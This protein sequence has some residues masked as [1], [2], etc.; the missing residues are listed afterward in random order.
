MK[1]TMVKKVLADGSSCKKCDQVM[2]KLEE[3]GYISRIDEV[4]EARENDPKSQGAQLAYVL[5]VTKAPFFV[6][7]RGEPEP[8][9]YTIYFKLVKEVFESAR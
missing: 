3:S 5:G 8:E 7:D 2:Q 9:V 4:L 1:I 6:V